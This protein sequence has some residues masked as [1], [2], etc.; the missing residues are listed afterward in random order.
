[1]RETDRGGQTLFYRFLGTLWAV[2]SGAVGRNGTKG[3]AGSSA[4]SLLSGSSAS[5]TAQALRLLLELPL[6]AGPCQQLNISCPC[7]L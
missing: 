4:C 2:L 6:P 1:M 3:R 7:S 5:E